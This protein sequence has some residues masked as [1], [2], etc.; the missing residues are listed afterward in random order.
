MQ[1]KC[2][3]VC[4]DC[5]YRLFLPPQVRGLQVENPC[6]IAYCTWLTRLWVMCS[7]ACSR[8]SYSW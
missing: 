7:S 6:Y 4:I 3:S 2:R 1:L 5:M 8:R